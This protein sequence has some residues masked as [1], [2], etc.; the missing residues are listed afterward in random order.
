MTL[1]AYYSHDVSPRMWVWQW[2]H[3]HIVYMLIFSV[4]YLIQCDTHRGYHH[5]KFIISFNV[6]KS[7]AS[8]CMLLEMNTNRA[9]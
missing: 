3:L 5:F 1:S 2:S 8:S 9:S 7:N 6:F 4:E